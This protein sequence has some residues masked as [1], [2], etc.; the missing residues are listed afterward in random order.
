M[1]FFYG[2][3]DIIQ[4]G[5]DSSFLVLRRSSYGYLSNTPRRNWREPWPYPVLTRASVRNGATGITTVGTDTRENNEQASTEGVRFR[6]PLGAWLQTVLDYHSPPASLVQYKD[7]WSN[8]DYWD[9]YLE[10]Y[11]LTHTLETSIVRARPWLCPRQEMQAVL[12]QPLADFPELLAR[13]LCPKDHDLR[14]THRWH[15]PLHHLAVVIGYAGK[16]NT[17]SSVDL[18]TRFLGFGRH[19]LVIAMASTLILI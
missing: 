6:F 5:M 11:V 18:S 2:S 9:S 10:E 14:G 1:I 13:N 17:P 16:Y 8:P 7:H 15:Q 3:G 4:R 19:V 12:F